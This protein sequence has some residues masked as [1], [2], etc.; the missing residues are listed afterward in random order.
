M[1]GLA[2]HFNLARQYYYTKAETDNGHDSQWVL[3]THNKMLI[4][5]PTLNALKSPWPNTKKTL[6]WTD[7]YSSLLSVLK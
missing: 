4:K 5:N 2:K 1:A 7:E 3:L 6:V